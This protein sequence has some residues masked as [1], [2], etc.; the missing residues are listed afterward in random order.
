[1]ADPTS[2]KDVADILRQLC[3]KMF[4]EQLV[5]RFTDTTTW[6]Q[7]RS[8]GVCVGLISSTIRFWLISAMNR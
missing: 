3:E 2:N 6:P 7:D 5:D 4:I 8:F 1:M